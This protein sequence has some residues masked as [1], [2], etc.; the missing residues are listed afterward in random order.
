MIYKLL[1]YT[2]LLA[3]LVLLQLV[4]LNNIQFSGYVNPFIY[5][6]LLL[7]IPVDTDNLVLLLIA[8]VTGFIMDIFGGTPGMHASAM[9]AAGFLRPFILRAVAVRDGYE[10]GSVPSVS[11]FG[12]RWFLVYSLMMIL[13]HHFVLFYME[14][15]S[16]AGFFH[17]L[18]RVLLSVIF[19]FVSVVLLEVYVAGNI[20]RT[21]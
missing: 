4:V 11:E 16:F 21:R 12:L 3:G 10:K 19:T 13:V 17:T 8:F 7:V 6:Y 18:L 15:F 1:K 5:I 14:V 20:R 2:G 9:V